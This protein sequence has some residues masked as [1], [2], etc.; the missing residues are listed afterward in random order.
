[1]QTM[2]DLNMFAFLQACTDASKVAL[3]MRSHPS[4][5]QQHRGSLIP[6]VYI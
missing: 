2:F 1:M 6:F 5:C 4:L 3:A